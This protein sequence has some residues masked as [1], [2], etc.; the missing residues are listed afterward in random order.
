M[1]IG[2]LLFAQIQPTGRTCHLSSAGIAPLAG[3][4]QGR[5]QLFGAEI[6]GPDGGVPTIF[7]LGPITIQLVRA[8]AI[9]ADCSR[10]RLVVLRFGW[11]GYLIMSF[12]FAFH[13]QAS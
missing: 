11:H 3:V 1:E 8:T 2:K 7:E 10:R 12:A 5:R 9:V 6:C 13:S 4:E